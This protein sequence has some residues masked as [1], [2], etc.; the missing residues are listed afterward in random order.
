MW[1]TVCIYTVY[2]TVLWITINWEYLLKN[3][4]FFFINIFYR[5]DQGKFNIVT[6]PQRDN[7]TMRQRDMD[8]FRKMFAFRIKMEFEQW[9]NSKL[10]VGLNT[11]SDCRNRCCVCPA[12]PITCGD[13]DL[14]IMALRTY[15]F[16]LITKLWITDDIKACHDCNKCNAGL[17][18]LSFPHRSFT[19][20]LISLKSNERLWAIHS[21]RSRKWAT[22][23]SMF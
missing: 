19:H 22:V 12:L 14:I 7:A 13:R 9:C 5:Q 11:V 21:D 23:S 15:S 18:I 1:Y 2:Y 10:I 17:G 8:K 3:S 20:L 6:T 4:I 16:F